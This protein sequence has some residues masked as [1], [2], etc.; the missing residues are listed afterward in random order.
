MLRSRLGQ[1]SRMA[2]ELYPIDKVEYFLHVNCKNKL[3]H[4]LP[5]EPSLKQLSPAL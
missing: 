1:I 2:S 3:I 4:N 5:N